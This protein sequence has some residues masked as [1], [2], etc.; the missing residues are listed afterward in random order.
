M[1]YTLFSFSCLLRDT[2]AESFLEVISKILLREY[3]TVT[4]GH[5][6][7]PDDGVRDFFYSFFC[8]PDDGVRDLSFF[9]SPDH[10]TIVFWRPLLCFSCSLIDIN[11]TLIR[12]YH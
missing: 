6:G 5:L 1:I 7:D 4:P 11:D 10:L 12:V 2:Y 8:D 9:G 3:D